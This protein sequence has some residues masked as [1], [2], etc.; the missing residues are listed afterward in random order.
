MPSVC[1][2]SGAPEAAARRVVGEKRLLLRLVDARRVDPPVPRPLVVEAVGADL[3]RVAVMVDLAGPR[4]EVVVLL[5]RLPERHDVGDR[6]AEVALKVVD[7]GGVGREAR[8]HRAARGTAQRELAVGAV[9]A[10]AAPRDHVEIRRVDDRVAVR[11]EAVVQVVGGDEQH[12]ASGFGLRRC[13]QGGARGHQK[14]A[15]R[16]DHVS[17]PV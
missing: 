10:H 12:V 6:L 7:L 2:S 1:S 17:T 5:E 14:M 4:D 16:Q 11:A 9:E 8:H 13:G 15:S 3:P